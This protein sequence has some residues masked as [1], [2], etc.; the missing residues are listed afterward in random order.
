VG[1]P[2]FYLDLFS[3]YAYLAAERIGSLIP[4][5]D[6][7]PIQLFGLFKLNGRQSWVLTDEREGNIA[8][9]QERASRYGL[10]PITWPR[11]F[12]ERQVDL[13]RGAV[14]A[15]RSG[16]IE[17][18]SLGVF[19]GIY[20]DGR[21]PNAPDFL[22]AAAAAAG[23]DGDALVMRISDQDV[24]DE[25]R[26]TTGEAHRAGVPGVPTVVIDGDVFWG[27]D[28]LGEAAEAAGPRAA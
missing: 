19:R 9:I 11:S 10:P 25:L 17:D 23:V 6:W 12:P 28:R 8:D 4:H 24:K 27:D 2:I 20:R 22:P 18:F 21:D 13:N 14:V 5:A 15:G 3:P 26:S 7:R 16:R 1:R